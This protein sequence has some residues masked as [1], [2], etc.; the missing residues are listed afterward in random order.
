M[1][2]GQ[3]NGRGPRRGSPRPP[4]HG[5]PCRIRTCD[6][7]IRSPL[8]YPA[9]PRARKHPCLLYLNSPL[10][11]RCGTHHTLAEKPGFEPGFPVSQET[12]LAGECLQPARPPLHIC[13]S[14]TGRHPGGFSPILSAGPAPCAPRREHPL[15]AEG[16]GFEPT[17]PFITGQRFSRPPPSASRPS[18]LVQR[19]AE[20]GPS[21]AFPSS[22][23]PCGG[24]QPTSVADSSGALHMDPFERSAFYI[25]AQRRCII[26]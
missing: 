8:L 9:E 22:P 21:A 19:A 25:Q 20:N 10:R 16:V 3:E 2:F 26:R 11:A 12:R 23:A 17:V 4:Y 18:L 7:R 24:L 1:P 14:P 13:R 15:L 5:A 6:L